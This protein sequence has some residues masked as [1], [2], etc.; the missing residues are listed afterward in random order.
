MTDLPQIS[1][2]QRQA[3]QQRIAAA[4]HKLATDIDKEQGNGTG[5]LGLQCLADAVAS[6]GFSVGISCAASGLDYDQG[7]S[8]AKTISV[9]F[10]DQFRRGF[11]D[12]DSNLFAEKIGDPI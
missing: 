10:F 3:N 2:A 9:E 11:N 7:E 1:E 8:I 12:P 4:L 5:V 6:V